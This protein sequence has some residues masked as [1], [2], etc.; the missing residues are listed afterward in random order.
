MQV[1]IL[2]NDGRP[3]KLTDSFT[4]LIFDISGFLK[5][6]NFGGTKYTYYQYDDFRKADTYQD[7]LVGYFEESAYL[8]YIQYIGTEVPTAAQL[9]QTD[10]FNFDDFI[11][12]VDDFITVSTVDFG[13]PYDYYYK[14]L[15]YE[16]NIEL[17]PY[18]NQVKNY[19]DIITKGI[20][21]PQ[22]AVIYQTFKDLN[23]NPRGLFYEKNFGLSI[24]TWTVSESVKRSFSRIMTLI[25]FRI[26]DI[27]SKIFPVIVDAETRIVLNNFLNNPSGDFSILTHFEK[28]IFIIEKSW[29][30]YYDPGSSLPHKQS[31]DPVLSNTPNEDEYRDYLL[32]LDNFYQIVYKIQDLV[33]NR[34]N[35]IKISYFIEILPISALALLPLEVRI[36]ALNELIK[37]YV[38]SSKESLV[39]RII[40]SISASEANSFLD[41]LLTKNGKA[42]VFE[43]LYGKMDDDRLGRYPFMIL[44][45]GAANRM[46]FVTG[47]YEIWKNS[48]YSFYLPTGEINYQS[49][50]F[51]EGK[52]LYSQDQ[53]GNPKQTIFEFGL[54]DTY[55]VPDPDIPNLTVFETT[56][57]NYKCDKGMKGELIPVQKDFDYVKYYEN[58]F[59]NRVGSSIDKGSK[60]I[61]I[62]YHLYFPISIA[63]HKTEGVKIP[64]GQGIPMFLFYYTRDFKKLQQ[65]DA[66]IN[67]GIEIGIEAIIFFTVGG[68]LTTLRHIRHVRQLLNIESAVSGGM[69]A[70]ETVLIFTGLEATAEAISV[71]ASVLYSLGSYNATILPDGPLKNQQIETNKA[72]LYMALI[73]GGTAGFLKYKAVKSADNVLTSISQGTDTNIPQDVLNVLTDLRGQR[74]VALSQ[75][76]ASLS[77]YEN[78]TFKFTSYSPELKNSFWED[79]ANNTDDFFERLDADIANMDNWEDLYLLDVDERKVLDF[80][81]NTQ[82]TNRIYRYY[83]E[84]DLRKIL[85]P[86]N[87][88]VKRSFLDDFGGV[89]N[90][91]FNNLVEDAEKIELPIE[92]SRTTVRGADKFSAPSEII[93]ILETDLYVNHVK[94]LVQKSLIGFEE[95]KRLYPKLTTN[96]TIPLSRIVEIQNGATFSFFNSLSNT[97]KKLLQSTNIMTARIQRFSGDIPVGSSIENVYISGNESTVQRVIENISQNELELNSF[98]DIDNYDLFEVFTKKALELKIDDVRARTNDTE[99]KFLYNFLQEYWDTADRFVIDIESKLYT[100]GNCQI[101]YVYLQ[102]LAEK[103]GK[104]INIRILSNPGVK[105]TKDI[106]KY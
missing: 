49:F 75:F 104:I 9:K 35:S 98:K 62:D 21:I 28:T 48:K 46:H 36:N 106:N 74:T 71:S 24:N 100:C 63:G 55:S 73:S 101:Y 60:T 79:F 92:F 52:P 105:S 1:A 68:G 2:K 99:M 26:N 94:L 30:Y 7:G 61:E 83:E 69:A 77:E 54:V 103:E 64:M 65:I 80:V 96:E 97:K 20:S 44:T 84:I 23:L 70:Q 56:W 93:D 29:G 43:I 42:T 51:N 76:Q 6:F 4:D 59:G 95:G 38:P 37:G 8:L 90:V 41:F 16:F 15:Y 11:A 5:E 32:G 34:D 87:Y 33:A 81:T 53:N 19:Y 58:E 40:Y 12:H 89:N 102:R 66:A 88:D 13:V 17:D 3:V 50:F 39:L 86:L 22:N 67:L 14:E 25:A 31:F 27:H 78:I 47:L 10:K 85:E 45:D 72:F 18:S 57:A 82:L 91:V